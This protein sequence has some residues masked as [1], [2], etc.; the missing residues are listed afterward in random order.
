MFKWIKSLFCK[1]EVV[2]PEPSINQFEDL[3]IAEEEIKS[4]EKE[5]PNNPPPRP[6]KAYV[7][8]QLLGEVLKTFGTTNDCELSQSIKIKGKGGK[9]ENLPC[10]YTKH[11]L[12]VKNG[13]TINK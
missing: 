12:G 4:Q 10:I 9:I 1:T 7:K 8:N 13:R 11:R 2:N 3:N 5:E 6:K